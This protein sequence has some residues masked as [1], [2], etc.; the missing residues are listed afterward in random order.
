MQRKKLFFKSILILFFGFVLSSC[1]NTIPPGEYDTNEV[2][3]VKKVIPGTIISKRPVHLRHKSKL[4]ANTNNNLIDNSYSQT[5]GIEYV[6][7]LHSGEII[8]VVQ[9]E[10]LKLKVKQ[11]ILVIYGKNTRVVADKGS[12]NF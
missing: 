3:K 10:D 12:E 1:Q 2:G 8:S 5:Q 9:S 7:K 11:K 6:I 4:N